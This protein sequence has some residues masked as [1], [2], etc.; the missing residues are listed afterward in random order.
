MKKVFVDTNVILDFLMK[1]PD[2]FEEARM[3]MAMGYHHCCELYMSSL[4]FSNIAY[5]AK[6]KL[7]GEALYKC[8]S[9]LRELISVSSVTQADVDLAIKLQAKD[10]EDALQYYSAKSVDVD[11]IVTRNVKDFS[12]S[13]IEILTPD[14]FV[15]F[16]PG[17]CLPLS[18]KSPETFGCLDKKP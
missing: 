9:S 16:A 11:C 10:F 1:R 13:E 4:S 6:T 18:V 3:I 17:K 8:F 2:F 14:E 7:K 12:F 15:E 5:I